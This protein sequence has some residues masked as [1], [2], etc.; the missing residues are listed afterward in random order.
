MSFL[1]NVR[2]L[3]RVGAGAGS[4]RT[5][6]GDLSESA[7]QDCVDYYGN[8]Y[9]CP[10]GDFGVDSES[11]ALAGFAA[12]MY[13]YAVAVQIAVPGLRGWEACEQPPSPTAPLCVGPYVYPELTMTVDGTFVQLDNVPGGPPSSSFA[14]PV[15]SVWEN[16]PGQIQTS[17]WWAGPASEDP[18]AMLVNGA[19]TWPVPDAWGNTFGQCLFTEAQLPGAIGVEFAHTNMEHPYSG[20]I[21]VAVVPY[22]LDESEPSVGATQYIVGSA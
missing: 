13:L 22:I 14:A 12:G 17:G 3:L 16:P 5:Y 11:G 19:P 10:A 2:G 6:F 8:A 4:T 21:N 1:Q 15:D 7:L 9:Q 18:W 20:Y